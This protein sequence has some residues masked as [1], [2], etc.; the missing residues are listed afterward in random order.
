MSPSP[1][2]RPGDPDAADQQLRAAR[3]GAVSALGRVL[4]GCRQ[5]LLLVAHERLAPDLRDKVAAS[6]LVQDT[7]LDAHRA[8]GRFRG[9][10]RDD[11]LAWL[12]RILLNNLADARRRYRGAGKRD[13]AREVALVDAPPDLLRPGLA[14][15]TDPPDARLAARE[16]A[17]AVRRALGQLPEAGRRAIEWRNY[18]LCS[19]A[20]IGRRLGK[21]EEAARKVWARAV[22]QLHDILERPA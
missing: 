3:D 8:F 11:L 14:R 15:G 18:E 12:R 2:G 1:T 10:T 7:F 17:E 16:Q 22:E 4:D 20:E 21:S 13:L 5:Y 6:D 19:F 9:A